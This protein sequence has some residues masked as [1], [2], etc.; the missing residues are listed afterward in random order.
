MIKYCETQDAAH[1]FAPS[2]QIGEVQHAFVLSGTKRYTL[3]LE[4]DLKSE[5][6]FGVWVYFWLGFFSPM[7]VDIS[8]FNLICI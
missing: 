3:L 6:T 7:K 4:H 2:L 1:H 8:N 5:K